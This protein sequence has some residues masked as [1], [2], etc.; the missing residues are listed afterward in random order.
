[1]LD[2]YESFF[3][4]LKPLLGALSLLRPAHE[5]ARIRA[6]LQGD[7]VDIAGL[8]AFVS[9]DQVRSLAG[10]RGWS[11]VNPSLTR[12]VKPPSVFSET[13]LYDQQTYLQSLLNRLD[14]M[15]MAFSLEGRV[16]FLDHRVVEFAAKVPPQLKLRGGCTKFLLKELGRRYLPAEII[17][18]PK[19]GLAVPISRWLARDGVLSPFADSLCEPNA[20]LRE[21][22][23]GEVVRRSVEEHRAGKADHGELLWALVNF[24]L[25]L[26]GVAAVP[27][28][29]DRKSAG[30]AL[31]A[32]A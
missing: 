22:L 3:P 8:A 7:G 10:L 5:R 26:R 1:L 12:R 31:H 23:D 11:G 21:Y 14:K 27:V 4:V 15:A 2:R 17:D 6:A 20:R 19:A 18:R 9:Q 16:P 28:R 29:D 13:L 24:E 25:W 30:A 32:G